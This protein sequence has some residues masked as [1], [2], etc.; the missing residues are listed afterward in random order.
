MELHWLGIEKVAARQAC[1]WVSVAVDMLGLRCLLDLPVDISHEQLDTQVRNSVGRSQ[2]V[3]RE[4][5]WGRSPPVKV[6]PSDAQT[7]PESSLCFPLHGTAFSLHEVAGAG[8]PSWPLRSLDHSSSNSKKVGPSYLRLLARPFFKWTASL[9]KNYTPG[10][11]RS[12]AGSCP[13]G[14]HS[15]LFTEPSGSHS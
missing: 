9:P 5:S 1:A 12:C 15:L 3:W 11:P 6:L 4:G 13:P 8:K 7:S 14:A 10:P 2:R